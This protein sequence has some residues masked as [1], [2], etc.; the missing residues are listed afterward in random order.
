MK[1]SDKDEVAVRSNGRMFSEIV[2][3]C[4]VWNP[5]NFNNH[6]EW[7]STLTSTIIDSGVI[8]DEVFQCLSQMCKVYVSCFFLCIPVYLIIFKTS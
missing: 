4:D 2:R 6:G 3:D 7:V 1:K 5:G 8:Q